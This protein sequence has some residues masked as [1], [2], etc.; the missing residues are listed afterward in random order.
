MSIFSILF[1]AGVVLFTNN[2]EAK[3][4]KVGALHYK[5]MF[6]LLCNGLNIFHLGK[7]YFNCLMI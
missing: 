2:A 1:G 6:W 7:R 4:K 3:G 5:R